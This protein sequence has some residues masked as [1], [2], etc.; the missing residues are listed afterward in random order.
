MII[1]CSLFFGF[2]MLYITEHFHPVASSII[3]IIFCFC[4]SG[5]FCSFFTFLITTSAT[6]HYYLVSSTQYSRSIWRS[7]EPNSS[8]SSSSSSHSHHTPTQHPT[9]IN[10]HSSRACFISFWFVFQ[11]LVWVSFGFGIWISH[12]LP[13]GC[14]AEQTHTLLM[15]YQYQPKIIVV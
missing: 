4:S 10:R 6:F 3:F 11:C 5:C 8:L 7:N 12:Q 2:Q 13:F 1:F 14:R 15:Y 9:H